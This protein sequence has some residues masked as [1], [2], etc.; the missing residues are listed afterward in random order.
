MNRSN[1][2]YK[3]IYQKDKE[4]KIATAKELHLKVNENF[5]KP[6]TYSVF[7][8]LLKRHGWSMQTPR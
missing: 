3:N 7:W 6:I 5:E 4:G 1:N 2:F 8:R